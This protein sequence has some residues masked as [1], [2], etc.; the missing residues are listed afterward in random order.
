[1]ESSEAADDTLILGGFDDAEVRDLTVVFWLYMHA[2]PPSGTCY[3]Y[4][5]DL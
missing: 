1:M 4:D 5:L 2:A 3:K